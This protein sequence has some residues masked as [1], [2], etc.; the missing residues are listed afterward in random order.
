MLSEHVVLEPFL[1]IPPSPLLLIAFYA[2]L[3]WD[4]VFPG[5]TP[6][7]EPGE[8]T[9]AAVSLSTQMAVKYAAVWYRC[10]FCVSS[11]WG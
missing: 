5:S 3:L 7:S 8:R 6:R 9:T 4:V 2:C 1:L 10:R 11:R